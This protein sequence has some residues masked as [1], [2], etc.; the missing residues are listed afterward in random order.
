M[1]PQNA[2]EVEFRRTW[3]HDVVKVGERNGDNPI[4]NLVEVIAVVNTRAL[5]LLAV[6]GTDLEE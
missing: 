4:A 2:V 3:T 6:S 5:E 1:I